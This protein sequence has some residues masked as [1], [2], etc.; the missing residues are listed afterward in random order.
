[1]SFSISRIILYNRA[2]FDH[3]E[4]DFK[5]KGISLL[6]ALNGGGKTTVLSHIADAWYEMVRASFPLEYE[7]KENKYYR[8]S[9]ANFSLDKHRASIVYIR[10]LVDNKTMDY[11]DVRTPCNQRDYDG[12]ITLENKIQYSQIQGSLDKA[13]NVKYLSEQTEDTLRLL[14]ISNVITFFPA[15]RHE[16]PGYLNT[17]FDIKLDFNMSAYYSGY[18]KNPI[19]V[20]SDLPSLANWLMDIVLDMNLTKN[21]TTSILFN[22]VNSIFT[23]SLRLKSGN[24]VFLG[25]GSR[26]DGIARIQVGERENGHQSGKWIKPVYPSI[27]NMS[28]GENALVCLF[29]EIVRQFDKIMP[30]TPLDKTEG[31]VLID[32]VD[33]HLH[34]R[35]QTEVLPKLFC[36][37]PNVQFLVSS[38]SPFTA[39]GLYNSITT[40][41]RLAI[42]DLDKN[43]I[44]VDLTSTQVFGRHTIVSLKKISDFKIYITLS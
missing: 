40:R 31:I 39:M 7:G 11:V 17:P 14:F 12:I 27:F 21:P 38:H 42:I 19:E 4:I 43:G 25:I 36:L 9:S 20:V 10:F 1:M 6:S 30:N 29:G 22:S 35:M 23:E 18:L 2:P 24:N 5:D 33:K 15:Y 16:R 13:N 41:N 37:F 28:S 32:E 8:T 3:I 26:N 34:I 44:S